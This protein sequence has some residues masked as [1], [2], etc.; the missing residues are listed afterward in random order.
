MTQ[1]FVLQF[2]SFRAD[3]RAMEFFKRLGKAVHRGEAKN[4]DKKKRDRAKKNRA[5]IKSPSLLMITLFSLSLFLLFVLTGLTT[6]KLKLN[7]CSFL[8]QPWF[9]VIPP[10]SIKKQ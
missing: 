4:E 8:T 7:H 2:L 3:P 10:N 5:F 1:C 6:V 9:L